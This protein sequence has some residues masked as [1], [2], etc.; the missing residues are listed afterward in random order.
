MRSEKHSPVIAC[1]YGKLRRFDKP[2]ILFFKLFQSLYLLGKIF[3]ICDPYC[4]CLASKCKYIS[5]LFVCV[6]FIYIRKDF[7][8]S[9]LFQRSLAVNFKYSYTLNIIAKKIYSV[10]PV[11][12]IR[13]QV[14][15][16]AAQSKLA[17]FGNKIN[18]FKGIF[19][20]CFLNKLMRQHISF[21]YLKD[22][23]A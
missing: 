9:K 17:R 20:E 19:N 22:A 7:N 6:A 23:G 15:N 11:V 8:C 12:G 16:A 21:R 4:R 5:K 2:F 13:K 18:S 14:Y 3:R 1:F 10:R